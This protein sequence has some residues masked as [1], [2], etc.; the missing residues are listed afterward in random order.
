MSGIRRPYSVTSWSIVMPVVVLVLVVI[1]VTDDR[2][3]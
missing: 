2:R 3:Q 1:G